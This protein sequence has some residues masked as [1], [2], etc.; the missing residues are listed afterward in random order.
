MVEHADNAFDIPKANQ[1]G[2]ARLAAVQALYQMDIGRVPL[3]DVLAEFEVYRLG[4]EVDGNEYRPA[5]AA[6]FKLLVQGVFDA[7]RPIDKVIADKMSGNWTL[8]RLDATVRA[9]L[10][11]GTFEILMRREVP[12]AV[13]MKEYLD[14][15]GAFFEDT[16]IKFINAVLDAIRKSRDEIELDLF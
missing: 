7:Q 10:R 14:I 8:S 1:R 12:E 2:S 6:Y 16:E 5:D 15:A 13:V 9:I 3:S 4:Q 11:A